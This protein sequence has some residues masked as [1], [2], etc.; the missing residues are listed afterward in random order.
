MNLK[1]ICSRLVEIVP[2]EHHGELI[3]LLTEYSSITIDD[4]MNK[5]VSNITALREA[6]F[7]VSSFDK[8]GGKDEW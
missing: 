1:H 8:E 4:A 3:Q 2:V 6:G 7:I 5:L